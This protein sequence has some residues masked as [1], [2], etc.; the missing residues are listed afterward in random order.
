MDSEMR[1]GAALVTPIA[2]YDTSGEQVCSGR[3]GVR[4][5]RWI[6]LA[7][8]SETNAPFRVFAPTESER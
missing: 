4:L 1:G 3:D 2:R 6:A 8:G 5:H 7:P